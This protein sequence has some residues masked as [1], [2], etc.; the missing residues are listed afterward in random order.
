MCYNMYATYSWPSVPQAYCRSRYFVARP[1]KLPEVDGSS[2]LDGILRSSLKSAPLT[3]S[4][5][6]LLVRLNTREGFPNIVRSLLTHSESLQRKRKRVSRD[7]WQMLWR[8]VFLW[9]AK[10]RFDGRK[11]QA[12]CSSFY[13]QTCLQ[14]KRIALSPPSCADVV[15]GQHHRIM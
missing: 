11:P 13:W 1:V 7:A 4:L 8:K 14:N 5:T 15:C 6:T 10:V 9:L 2:P 3:S 12:I